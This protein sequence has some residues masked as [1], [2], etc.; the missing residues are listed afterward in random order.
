MPLGCKLSQQVGKVIQ[1]PLQREVSSWDWL[2]ILGPKE[3]ELGVLP[4]LT[5]CRSGI[6]SKSLLT[7]GPCMLTSKNVM[8]ED[9]LFCYGSS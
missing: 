7:L 8:E 3:E 6:L 9:I 4:P 2:L 5:L 1:Q